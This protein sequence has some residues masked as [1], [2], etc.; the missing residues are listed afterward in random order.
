M[1]KDLDDPA[2]PGS[3]GTA[4]AAPAIAA[5]VAATP[6]PSL[7]AMVRRALDD[8][9][10][11]IAALSA[12]GDRGLRGAVAKAAADND[13]LFAST[14]RFLA[15][16]AQL[17][18]T[19]PET[20]AQYGDKLAELIRARDALNAAAFA[21]SADTVRLTAF[22]CGNRRLETEGEE[23]AFFIAKARAMRLTKWAMRAI[24]TVALAVLAHTILLSTAAL[25]GRTII[26]ENGTIRT[27][28]ERTN[29]ILARLEAPLLAA[30][31]PLVAVPEAAREL[32]IHPCEGFF[33]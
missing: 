16:C 19:P 24:A 15:R 4:R 27:E 1:R 31:F 32:R 20:I 22:Y 10:T 9:K 28:F 18:T 29:E 21:A 6:P 25:N 11:L 14:E 26:A 23:A 7:V 30:I 13:S 8:V 2:Q 3:F 5:A 33:S 12:R 17:I